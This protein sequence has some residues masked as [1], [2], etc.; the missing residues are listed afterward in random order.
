[1]KNKKTPV[2]PTFLFKY[3]LLAV[4]ISFCC[5]ITDGIAGANDDVMEELK[6]LKTRIEQLEKK[7]AE[8]DTKIEQQVTKLE[9]Q[10]T[11]LED[12]KGIQ[13]AL[14]SLEFSL[15]ATSVIQG[16]INSD[17]NSTKA[18]G[19]AG[20]GDDTDVNY[21]VD[22]EITSKIGEHGTALLYLEAGEGEGLN[23]EAGGLTGVNADAPMDDADVQ[24]SEVWYEH[25]FMN[26]TLVATIG[27]MDVTR[28]LDGN[29][30][31]NDECGQF[32]SDMF[33]NNITVA[34]PDY[35]YGARVSY[36][37]GDM[38]EFNTTM[39]EADSDF[40]DLFDDNFFMVEAVLKPTLGELEGNYRFYAWRNSGEHMK[41]RDDGRTDKSGEGF[42]VS[43]DQQVSE[44]VTGFLR[45]G[46]AN[47]DIYAVR[48][49]W[50]LGFQVAGAMWGR[51]DDMFGLAF[52]RAE[53]S[54]SYRQTLRDAGFGTTPA[55]SR[56]EAYYSYRVNNNLAISPDVQWV[57]G[58]A[59][60]SNSD[61]VTILGVRAQLDF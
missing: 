45:W 14:G 44:N 2:G 58:L 12:L 43:F 32:L 61:A 51:D 36:Y 28:W 20:K 29:A 60:A 27:K 24:V 57:D 7:L 19:F 46:V 39:V 38:L 31:A 11:S 18:P 42:G 37:A 53:T 41:L 15:G 4:M 48:R 13:D 8:Q 50:S 22:L 6:A 59:G 1:M 30:V 25:N 3:F 34:W 26:D 33:V 49:S 54:G 56:L 47:D 55:E 40:E 35:A 21:S 10:G 5:N 16:T 23:S 9:E 17:R 52:G